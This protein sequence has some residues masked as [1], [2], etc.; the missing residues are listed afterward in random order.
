[1]N[2]HE[3]T[4]YSETLGFNFPKYTWFQPAKYSVETCFENSS[5]N[6]FGLSNQI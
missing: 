3:S 6:E 5:E 4:N 1:M 2:K